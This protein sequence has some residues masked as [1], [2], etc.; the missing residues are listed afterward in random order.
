M[1]FICY[2]CTN[3]PVIQN[4]Y[5]M[6]ASGLR[7]TDDGAGVLTGTPTGSGTIDYDTG[8]WAL[9]LDATFTATRNIAASFISGDKIGRAH[10]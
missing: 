6:T 8:S 2:P 1:I 5:V 7:F 4:E 9:T 3:N 10:V